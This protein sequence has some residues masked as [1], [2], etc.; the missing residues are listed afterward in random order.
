VYLRNT[1]GSPA[2]RLGEGSGLSLSPDGKWALARLNV[3]PSP[4][5]LYPTGVGEMKQA[6]DDGINHTGAAFLPDGKR[7]VFT[8]TEPG[9]GVRLYAE[10]LEDGKAHAIS[11]EGTGAGF[12]LSPNGEFVADFGPDRKMYLFPVA[13]GEAKVVPGVLAQEVPTGWSPDGQSL[14]VLSRGE[15]PAKVFRVD[16]ATGQRTFWKAVE[17]A[18]S[19]G[20]D[21]IG[22]V[23]MSADNKAYVYSYVRT[24]S[25]LYLVEGLK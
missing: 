2:I 4:L 1:D 16:L 7:F 9:H 11:P 18:D 19:A 22:R 23:L 24:L 21:T 8:G 13:G 17:P 3:T 6:K 25:D 10:S 12:A 15:V 20:I 14:F 5:V